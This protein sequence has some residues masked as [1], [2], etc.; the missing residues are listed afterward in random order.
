[1]WKKDPL[2]F[3]VGNKV[4]NRKLSASI[5]PTKVERFFDKNEIIVSKTDL[6]GN[7]IYVNDVFLKISSYVESDILG[8]PHN[9]IRHPEMPRVIFQLLWKRIISGRE[10][11]AYVNNLASN[12]DNYWVIAHVTP[13]FDEQMNITGY[14]SSRRVPNVD[15]LKSTIIPMYATLLQIE[16]SNSSRKVGLEE[17]AIRLNEIIKNTGVSY[18]EF[19]L[20]L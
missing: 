7:L 3:S 14:H 6:K 13:S 2:D 8:Q 4:A 9:I 15:I 20:S 12:G 10:I 17:S 19:I 16:K 18:D 11:F 5:T 1:M